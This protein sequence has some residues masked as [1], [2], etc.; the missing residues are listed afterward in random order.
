MD[1]TVPP[2]AARLLDFIGGIEAPKGYN[3]IYA[4]R[5]GRLPKPITKMTIAE[6]QAHQASGWPAKS[7]ASGRYQ[8]MRATLKELRA[9]LSL[10]DNQVFNSDLQDRL[11]YHL[12][13][14]RG[15]DTFMAGKLS[16]NGFALNLA[17][18]WASLPVLTDCKGASR[19]I[20][21]GQSYYAGDGLNKSLVS[22]ESVEA[23]LREVK[24]IAAEPAEPQP[25][26]PAK[27][28]NWLASLI[29]LAISIL[30]AIFKR[31]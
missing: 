23:L 11:A 20:K 25:T 29:S 5:Q 9:E 16:L 4:N 17:K 12:L 8:F 14:R 31:K 1:R 28:A 2:G 10:G 21:R 22:P 7:T 13:K 30:S 6:L 24:G 26:A 18:E 19:Q 3:V 15:Y 27:P